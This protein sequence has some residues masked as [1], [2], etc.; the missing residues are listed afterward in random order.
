MAHELT[1]RDNKAEMAYVGEVPWHG[2]GQ[3][4][5]K[6]ASIE[7]WTEA[8]GMNWEIKTSPV[9]YD[10]VDGL[11]L[12]MDSRQVLYR[13][14]N[15]FPLSIVS[16]RYNIVQPGEVMEFFRDIS[17]SNDFQLDTAG[18][19]FD[20]KRF[21]ALARIGESA[22][23]LGNDQIDGYL[24]IST[25]CDGSL[26][27]AAQFT[28]CRVV[29]NNTLSM[30]L[31]EKNK[32]EVR[33]SHRQIFNAG[34]MKDKLGIARGSFATFIKA[35]RM[36]ANKKMSDQNA[37]QFFAKLLKTTVMKNHENIGETKAFQKMM[38]LFKGEAIGHNLD[39][40]Q[41]T[42]WAAI[43]SV[44]EF[45]DHHSGQRSDS[46]RLANAWFGA[47]DT[48]KTTALEMALAI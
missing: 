10:A 21:W 1:I 13:S 11:Q 29:C 41:N 26:Q 32:K 23:V 7:Q 4:L 43:N 16:S 42:S 27:T 47:G 25:S 14:D 15:H 19:M 48:L 35:S 31:N 12:Q 28:S 22:N 6:G 36:L 46:A 5:E 39:G 44:T 18:T 37:E 30:A 2:L 24:L 9:V 33:I 3:K 40:C 38:L 8:A 34:D 45:I 17:E 20:G